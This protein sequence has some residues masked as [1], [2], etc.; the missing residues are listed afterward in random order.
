MTST[1]TIADVATKIVVVTNRGAWTSKPTTI[2]KVTIPKGYHNGSGYVDTSN[3][4]N[5]S[6]TF[7]VSYS[8]Y[9]IDI[10]VKT[11]SS[12]KISRNTVHPYSNLHIDADGEN[13]YTCLAGTSGTEEKTLN[14]SS[15]NS[16]SIYTNFYTTYY[17][18][19]GHVITVELA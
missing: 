6:F 2:G 7:K 1:T 19:Q 3:F 15:Y 14:I 11:Y 4:S 13:I 9:K 8:K 17:D 12:L 10:D 18:V 5:K 16:I